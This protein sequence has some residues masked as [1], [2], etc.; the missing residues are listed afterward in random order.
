MKLTRTAAAIAI[1]GGL[2]ASTAAVAQATLRAVCA[3]PDGHFYCVHFEE[4]G[5]ASCRE[6]V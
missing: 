5:R 2:L 4:I 3:F 1:C 6:R